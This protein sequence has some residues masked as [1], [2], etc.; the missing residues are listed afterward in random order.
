MNLL[1]RLIPA[2]IIVVFSLLY[3]ATTK[4]VPCDDYCQQLYRLDTMVMRNRSYVGF[5]APC[6]HR[7]PK[8]DTLCVEINN[9][10]SIDWNLF[11]DTV[12]TYATQVG[13]KGQTILV[14]KFGSPNDTLAKKYCP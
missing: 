13:M 7:V 2:L 14:I 6:I 5:V 10:P 4:V 1:K 3:V 9:P 8:S 12:C 11:A